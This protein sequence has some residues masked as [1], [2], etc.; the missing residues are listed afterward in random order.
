MESGCSGGKGCDCVVVIIIIVVGSINPGGEG[1]AM[2]FGSRGKESCDVVVVVIV[3]IVI[4]GC[5][6]TGKSC[7]ECACRGAA[8][9][10]VGI[11]VGGVFGWFGLE[12]GFVI[13]GFGNCSN[14]QKLARIWSQ[15]LARVLSSV[16]AS[17]RWEQL[18]EGLGCVGGGAVMISA[19]A[20]WY[21]AW[22]QF[23]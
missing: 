10:V 15:Q 5:A 2:E 21:G 8:V 7:L 6:I 4:A 9:E 11:C 20:N 19:A 17:S 23:S 3:V 14:S 18:G 12:K 22:R 1:W 13:V 16:E